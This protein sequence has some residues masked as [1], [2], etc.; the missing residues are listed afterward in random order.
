MHAVALRLTTIVA[1]ILAACSYSRAAVDPETTLSAYLDGLDSALATWEITD[2][3]RG[4]VVDEFEAITDGGETAKRYKSLA[5]RLKKNVTSI[6]NTDL[7]ILAT[8][9][10]A[11]VKNLKAA[12]ASKAQ[13]KRAES[14]Y[15]L[16]VSRIKS[17][18]KLLHIL[19]DATARDYIRA[20]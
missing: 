1:V 20:L 4:S 3:I 13:L 17:Q 6:M 16:T 14:A 2:E 18:G 19:I 7:K 11:A 8:S 10:K 5:S 15:K 9:Y 12:K